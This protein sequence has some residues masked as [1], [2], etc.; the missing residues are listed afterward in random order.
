MLINSKFVFVHM[1]KTGGTF[2]TTV[3]WTL[4]PPPIT[5]WQR[6]L[7]TRARRLLGL[8]GAHARSYGLLEVRE[9]QH[10]TCHEIPAEAAHL[11]IV[12]CVRN[13]FDWYV[14]HYE[15]G[16]WKGTFERDRGQQPAPDGAAMEAVLPEF[17]R[18]H[19]HFPELSFAEYLDLCTL[20]AE[21][22]QQ[23]GAP[24]LGL[25]T[26]TFLRYYFRD[27]A[28]AAREMTVDFVRTGDHRAGMFDVLFLRMQQ[29]NDDLHRF[30][31][32]QDYR[33]EDLQF[34]LQKPRELPLGRGRSDDQP[35][36]AY[37]TPELSQR[38]RGLDGPLLAMFPD[39]D[40]GAE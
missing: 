40:P 32:T 3:M 26:H 15:F 13:P 7:R 11:P 16:W 38:V 19:P 21:T 37:Y 1:P 22:M 31:L 36:Q 34:V 23:P 20:A 39:L 6:W 8:P 25:C 27:P 33:P 2:V 14:S 5:T 30:L 35:W 28:A 10:G 29:L 18:S 12:S 17:R 4:H 9:P 24:R